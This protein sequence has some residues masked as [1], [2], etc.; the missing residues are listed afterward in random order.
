MPASKARK[1]RVKPQKISKTS[2]KR[3]VQHHHT[4]RYKN[5]TILGISL[6]FA[7]FLY[8]FE[9]FHEFLL[10][11]GDWGYIGAFIAG[12]LFVSTFTFATGALILLILAES[13]NIWEI[14][15]LAGLGGMVGDFLIFR[16]IK[17]ELVDEIIPIYNLL[18]GTHLT[19]ILSTKYF[20]WA[21]PV[22]GAVLIASPLPDEIGVSLLGISKLSS[23]RFL[24]IAFILD[25]IGVMLVVSASSIIK[26]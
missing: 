6:I 10:A 19:R 18:G 24:L 5:L 23:K 4:Y 8:Q 9:P 25:A 22:I 15:L 26:P 7:A 21:M 14:G 1:T 11:L 2:K 12:I 13:L 16:F 20:R 17:D 3:S